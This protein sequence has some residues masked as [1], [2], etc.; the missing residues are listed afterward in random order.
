MTPPT[1]YVDTDRDI[2][3][4][5]PD[6]RKALEHM[7]MNSVRDVV[8]AIQANH[9]QLWAKDDGLVVTEVDDKPRCRILRFWIAAGDLD[10]VLTLTDDIYEW[11]RYI[12]CDRA[13]S[14]CRKGW[15]RVMEK[16]GWTPRDDLVFLEKDLTATE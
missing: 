8:Q 13:T 10:D 7:D 6:I 2:R 1:P 12:G 9:A 3:H 5:L 11:G 15:A 4:F 14:L 16:D